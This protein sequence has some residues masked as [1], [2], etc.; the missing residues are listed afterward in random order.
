MT[1]RKRT[2]KSASASKNAPRKAKASREP[3]GDAVPTKTDSA[4]PE[5][6]PAPTVI[7]LDEDAYN[8]HLMGEW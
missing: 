7:V 5:A 1:T 3:H 2:K 8:A 6:A 4:L